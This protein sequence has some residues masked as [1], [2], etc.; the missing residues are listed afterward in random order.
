MRAKEAR[1]I[2]ITD[3]LASKGIEPIKSQKSG[4]ELWYSSPIRCGDTHPSFKVDTLKNLWFD[5]GIAVGG[6]TLDLVCRLESMNVREALAFLSSSSFNLRANK[7]TSTIE[8]FS[9]AKNINELRKFAG[10]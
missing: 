6:N 2:L 9:E 3:Y 8:L 5:F 1:L 7:L 10:E 4:L